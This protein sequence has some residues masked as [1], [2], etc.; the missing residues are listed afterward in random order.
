MN[1]FMQLSYL[2]VI[3]FHKINTYTILI[4]GIQPHK[5]NGIHSLRAKSKF[6]IDIK[7]QMM[8]QQHPSPNHA[9]QEETWKSTV[10]FFAL[11]LNVS[12]FLC[13]LTFPSMFTPK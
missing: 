11:P 13:S 10:L 2:M 7:K 8:K 3:N 4:R 12:V 6:K 9:M 1:L 5:S